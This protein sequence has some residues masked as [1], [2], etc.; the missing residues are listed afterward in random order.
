MATSDPNSTIVNGTI[1]GNDDTP[2]AHSVL[3]TSKQGTNLYLP[4]LASSSLKGF[5]DE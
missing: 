1:V 3:Q 2:I 5:Y 4:G